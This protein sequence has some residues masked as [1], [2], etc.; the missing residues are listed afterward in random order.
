MVRKSTKQKTAPEGQEAP[1]PIE[2]VVTVENSTHE[3]S[4]MAVDTTG[5]MAVD[6]IVEDDASSNT[7]VT[8]QRKT[9]V[10][11]IDDVIHM[12]ER[13]ASIPTIVK[14]LQSIRKTLDGAQIKTTKK[15]RRPNK[16]NIFV[17]EQ[18]ELLKGSDMNATARFKVCIDRWNERKA[19]EAAA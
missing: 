13:Q 9:V 2:A 19:I 14:Q 16:Y 17:S 18:M 11:K 8:K 3:D 10:E 1:E 6:T 7:K 4:A 12:A 15:T 5:A